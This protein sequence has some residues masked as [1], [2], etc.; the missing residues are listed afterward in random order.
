MIPKRL[1]S[2]AG[3]LIVTLSLVAFAASGRLDV[4]PGD[5]YRVCDCSGCACNTISAMEGKCHCGHELV[6][7]KVTRAEK[8]A[9]YFKAEKWDKER[10]FITVGKY[11]CA[12]GPSCSCKT[13][14]QMAGKCGCGHDLTKVAD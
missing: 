2:I 13:I 11:A 4:K 7:A 3:V 8:D 1:L 10:K 12:C 14:S 5:E 9:A 6:K